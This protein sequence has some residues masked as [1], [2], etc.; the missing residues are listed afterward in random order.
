MLLFSAL[1]YFAAEGLPARAIQVCLLA[2]NRHLASPS[3]QR[4]TLTRDRALN[5]MPMLQVM[6]TAMRQHHECVRKLLAEHRGYESNTVSL[7]LLFRRDSGETA[8][9]QH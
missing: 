2:G 8:D 3:G 6:D 1:C 9:H 4:C 7:L 5:T